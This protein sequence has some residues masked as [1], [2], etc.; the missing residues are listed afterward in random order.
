MLVDTFHYSDKR[1]RVKR[2]SNDKSLDQLHKM[3]VNIALQ[4]PPH[5]SIIAHAKVSSQN[6][7]LQYA[8]C[9]S[10]GLTAE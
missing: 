8:F 6:V 5:S 3:R 10:H 9:L 1:H 2:T 7:P 4:T